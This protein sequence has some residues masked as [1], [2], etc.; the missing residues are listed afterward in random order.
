MD[1]SKRVCPQEDDSITPMEPLPPYPGPP[2]IQPS[3]SGLHDD[4]FIG[5]GNRRPTIPALL[6]DRRRQ[7]QEIPPISALRVALFSMTLLVVCTLFAAGV[8]ILGLAYM[9]CVDH[10]HVHHGTLCILGAGIV[11]ILA[12]GLGV[13]R[14]CKPDDSPSE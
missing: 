10:R 7:R 11:L 9:Q 1:V 3:C 6:I 12:S 8:I 4:L 5:A 13:F 14:V 2:F